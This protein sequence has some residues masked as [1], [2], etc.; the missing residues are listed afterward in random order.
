MAKTYKIIHPAHIRD[1]ADIHAHGRD[2]RRADASDTD[3][4]RVDSY[5][6]DNGCVVIVVTLAD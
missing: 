2:V 1:W 4:P 3:A 6:A 5:D